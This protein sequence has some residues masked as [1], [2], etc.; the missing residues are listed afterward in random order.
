MSKTDRSWGRLVPALGALLAGVM[1]LAACGNAGDDDTTTKETTTSGATTT[2]GDRTPDESHGEFQPIEGVPGVTDEAINFA[3]LSTGAANPLGY[4]L[5]D[6]VADGVEAY[7]A[8]RNSEGGL[9]GR[10]LVLSKVVDDELT[11][12]ELEA[13][14]LIDAGDVFAVISEPLI[15]NGFA[16]FASA[17]VPVYTNAVPSAEADGVDSIFPYPG[18][19]CGTSASRFHV[20]AAQLAGATKVGALGYGVSQ[21]SKDCV[22][23]QVASFENWG[24]DAGIELVYANNDLPYGLA[25]GVG[26]EVTAMKSAGVDFVLTCLDQNG[27]LTLDQEL[28][29]QGMADVAVQLPQG[30]ADYGFVEANADVLEGDV[31]SMPYRPFEADSQGSDIERFTD[32]MEQTGSEITDHAIEGWLDADLAY[33]GV[34]AAGPQFDRSKVVEATNQFTDYTAGGMLAPVDWTRQ[35]DAVTPDDPTTND[36]E[37]ECFAFVQVRSGAFEMLGDPAKPWVCWQT[38]DQSWSPPTPMTFQ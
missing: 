3:V 32:W 19:N 14:D 1:L 16:D 29:R 7:F 18:V 8:W 4:C 15:A 25:N 31:L 5:L 38:A 20:Y 13:L 22:D 26:P 24:A 11:N 35:H 23:A 36:N 21:A 2:T 9:H 37:I 34:L 27:A 6:C 17:G 33:Q 28:E 12:N 30:Y 10:K